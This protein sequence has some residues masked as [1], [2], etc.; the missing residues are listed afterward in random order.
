MVVLNSG[1]ATV[2]LLDRGSRKEIK[3]LRTGKEPHHL[4]P[5]P[6]DKSLIVAS[7]G[8]ND[9][10][11]LDLVTGEPQRR[12]KNIPDPYQIGFSPDRR[13]F[14]AAAFRLDRVDLYRG[15]D[16]SLVKRLP[17]PKVPSHIAFD[18]AS[19]FAFV[20]LQDSDEMAAIDLTQ[21]QLAWRL[22]VGKV[23]AGIWMTPDDQHL[24]IGMT[25]EDYVGV[26]DWRARKLIKKITTDKGAHNFQALGDG[27]HVFVSNR[28][29]NSVSLLDQEKL[30][31]VRS[32]PTLSGPDCMEVSAD[33]KELWLTARWAGKLVGI[34][35]ES[36]K[37]LAAIPV[38]RSPHGVYFRNHAPRR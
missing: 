34:D 30:A 22:P 16:Y 32:Y 31:L 6:D 29:G 19:R 3:R 25:G 10:L 2:S 15:A 7:A 13:W 38:G 14:V 5:T 37:Q 8:S 20:T 28:A 21:Q 33:R 4:M 36:G 1:D 12:V 27:R 11:F 17:A 35:I 24:L 18:G 26:V 9:L 23:P